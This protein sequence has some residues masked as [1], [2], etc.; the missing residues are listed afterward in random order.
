M[1]KIKLSKTERVYIQ[2]LKKR[3]GDKRIFRRLQ[4]LTLKAQGKSHQEI[5][6]TA[7]VSVDTVTDWLGIYLEKGLTE[8]CRPIDYDRRQSVI[9]PHI[10]DVKR[11]IQERLV[12]TLAELQ[13]LLKREFSID[14]EQSWLSR[15]CKKNAICL[16]RKP[17]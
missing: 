14:L 8:L 10:A 6:D 17:A 11:L 12:S 15:C 5:A 4:A 2:R 3:T 16:T 7:G 1:Y 9:D 13:I